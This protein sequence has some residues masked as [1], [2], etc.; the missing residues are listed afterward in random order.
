MASNNNLF[1]GFTTTRNQSF[2]G[3]ENYI[4]RPS[5]LIGLGNNQFRQPQ[6]DRQHAARETSVVQITQPIFYA[7]KAFSERWNRANQNGC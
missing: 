3:N 1:A 5:H 2:A 6:Q 4:S 7:K